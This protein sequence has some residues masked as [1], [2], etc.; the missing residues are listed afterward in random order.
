MAP[1]SESVNVVVRCRPLNERELSGN[2][3]AAVQIDEANRQVHL[4]DAA[5][6]FTF[7]S[8]FG[9]ESEQADLFA[10]VAQPIVEGAL[11]GYNGT[12]FAYGQTGTGKT[13]TMD[14]GEG[15][16]RGIIP[17][18]FEHVFKTIEESGFAQ[19]IVQASFLEIYMEEFRDLLKLDT[20]SKDIR[21]VDS[22]SGAKVHGASKHP[23]TSCTDLAKLLEVRCDAAA[24]N[25]AASVSGRTCSVRRIPVHMGSA[26]APEPTHLLPTPAALAVV[27]TLGDARAALGT[28]H[29]RG[30]PDANIRPTPP[31]TACRPVSRHAR[32]RRK[33]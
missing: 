16:Q 9:A 1:H 7:D 32:W 11:S 10:T 30:P 22:G 21:V 20:P 5:Q 18:A 15:E 24:R 26:L 29:P 31:C 13:Y 3:T 2:E 14:G 25:H 28:F 23:V 19:C 27:S 12:I 4:G 33:R 8:V 6:T 17:R